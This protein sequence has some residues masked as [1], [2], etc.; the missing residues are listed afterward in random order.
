MDAERRHE[1]LSAKFPETT[2]PLLRQIESLQQAASAQEE[3]WRAS[4]QN[5]SSR[6]ADAEVVLAGRAMQPPAHPPTRVAF[7]PIAAAMS[8]VPQLPLVCVNI[9]CVC[10]GVCT[11]NAAH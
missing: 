3:A 7:F 6:L 10:V 8:A 4:D 2:R 9:T 11:H 1:E 5:L